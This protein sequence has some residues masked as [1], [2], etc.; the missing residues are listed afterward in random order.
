M[1]FTEPLVAHLNDC[2][3]RVECDGE[4]KGT[5]FFVGPGLVLTCAHSVTGAREIAIVLEAGLSRPAFVISGMD[6]DEVERDAYQQPDAALLRISDPPPGHACV[7]L[8]SED[9]AIGTDRLILTA[10]SRGEND[11]DEIARSGAVLYL[12]SLF[13][14]AGHTLYKFSHGQV[15]RG[16][17][18]GPV[19]NVRTGRVCA[20]VDSSRS[21]RTDLGGFG[22]PI[23]LVETIAPSLMTT[24]ANF[25]ETDR[26][27]TRAKRSQ[28][29]NAVPREGVERAGEYVGAEERRVMLRRVY[30]KWV[31]DVLQAVSSPVHVELLL[32]RRI[33]PSNG[34]VEESATSESLISFLEDSGEGVVLLGGPG[35]GKTTL[36]ISLTREVIELAER[37]GTVPIPI[38]LNLSSWQFGSPHLED[39]VIAQLQE[40][41]GVPRSTASRW[42]S[43]NSLLLLFDGLDELGRSTA[44]E[45]I[46]AIRKF[47]Q[48]HGPS[49]IVVAC[50]ESMYDSLRVQ[51]PG[52]LVIVQPLSSQE[53]IDACRAADNA[54]AAVLVGQVEQVFGP[55]NSPLLLNIVLQ[56]SDTSKHLDLDTASSKSQIIDQLLAAY[57]KRMLDRRSGRYSSQHT[58]N[59][60]GSLAQYMR[61]RGL[62]EFQI[63]RITPQWV[64]KNSYA[65]ITAVIMGVIAGVPSGIIDGVGYGLVHGRQR[66]VANGI[67]IGVLFSLFVGLR[68]YELSCSP[69]TKRWRRICILLG[70][71]TV[72]SL[73]AALVLGFRAMAVFGPFFVLVYL[74]FGSF[75]TTAPVEQ[76]RWNPRKSMRGFAFGLTVG[77][78]IG[79]VDGVRGGHR[80]LVILTSFGIGFGVSVAIF[81]AIALGLRPMLVNS[82]IRPNEG[83]YRSTKRA[84]TFGFICF[85][86][87]ILAFGI[88]FGIFA[89]D[90]VS[91]GASIRLAVVLGMGVSLLGGALNGIEHVTTRFLIVLTGK[92]P[93]NY[94]KFLDEAVDRLLLYRAGSGYMFMHNSLLNYLCD[95]AEDSRSK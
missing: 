88:P 61:A 80:G 58:L 44:E 5:G 66:G 51:L 14:Q 8:A 69:R 95:S 54:G 87:G 33:Q 90:A 40:I 36:L 45:C 13:H 43:Q 21:V 9:P 72:M 2:V 64:L 25:H 3:V 6:M 60:L 63:D 70:G 23:S 37:D 73:L 20:L 27:W 77:I 74:S 7:R 82:R 56:V 57:V 12:E 83:V 39:W 68:A 4:F 75:A 26:R 78:P 47:L 34:L 31:R 11:P 94:I 42:M 41:Y 16:F 79:V 18:G 38:L 48:A 35:S 59:W 32:R 50:Q 10:Y 89:R 19:L 93:F 92:A 55:V 17:S 91:L 62:S 46:T 86:L 67:V 24:N 15:V 76:V 65:W 85:M 52:D 84:L 28:D 22:V 1:G 53:V 29:R 81:G 49:R 71:G 30:N